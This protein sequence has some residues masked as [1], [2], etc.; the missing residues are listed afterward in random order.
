MKKW[1][2]ELT[3]EVSQ[4]WI[5]DGFDMNHAEREQQLIDAIKEMLPYA[6]DSEVRV[7]IKSNI[8][9]EFKKNLIVS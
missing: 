4:N 1:K 7:Q 5:D 9:K 6:Y 3:V 8:G 2:I